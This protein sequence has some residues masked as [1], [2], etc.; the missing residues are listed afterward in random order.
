L[1]LLTMGLYRRADT[2]LT[3]AAAELGQALTSST[4]DVLRMA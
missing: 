4:R 3:Q 2:Q 1:P